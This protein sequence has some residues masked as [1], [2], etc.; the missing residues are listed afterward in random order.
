VRRADWSR[1]RLHWL[2]LK[3]AARRTERGARCLRTGTVDWTS[4]TSGA[5]DWSYDPRGLFARNFSAPRRGSRSGHPD[6]K[7]VGVENAQMGW[8]NAK[9][10]ARRTR[11]REALYA[12]PLPAYLPQVSHSPLFSRRPS[13]PSG[14][15]GLQARRN[16]VTTSEIR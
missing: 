13:F 8:F 15:V 2:F 12:S 7:V 6:G 5:H 3:A 16:N 14:T 4:R 10:G 11:H 1:S 9:L